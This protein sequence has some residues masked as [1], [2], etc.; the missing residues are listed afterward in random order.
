[1]KERT[2]EQKRT[3]WNNSDKK[4]KNKK[5]IQREQQRVWLAQARKPK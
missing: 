4:I 2:S 1:M 3:K 5:W